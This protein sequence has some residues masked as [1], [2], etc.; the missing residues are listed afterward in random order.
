[1]FPTTVWT[2]VHA[3][4]LDDSE[5][6]ERFAASY[7]APVLATV[8]AC[9]VPAQEAEDLCH[10]VFVRLLRGRVLERADAQRG[11]FRALLGTVTRN[12]VRDW[13]RRRREAPVE[14]PELPAR[15][16]AAEAFSREWALWL[17][18]RGLDRLAAEEPRH[19][20]VIRAH[21]DGPEDGPEDGAEDGVPSRNR[22]WI[23]RGRL[24]RA[25]RREIALTC[26]SPDEVEDELA[27]LAPYLRP[28][29]NRKAETSGTRTRTGS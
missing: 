12:A 13:F 2:L 5:A 16:D 7:R 6:L 26:R 14:L 15:D 27:T 17:V 11:R 19:F 28:G 3:A 23:A 24:M 29:E 18:T 21:L 8:R 22:L 25:L 1:M 20:D 4:G 9:G 10:D